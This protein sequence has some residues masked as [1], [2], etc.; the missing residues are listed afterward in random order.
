MRWAR[1]KTA[2]GRA[3]PLQPFSATCL[4]ALHALLR[5]PIVNRYFGRQWPL[6]VGRT[7]QERPWWDVRCRGDAPGAAPPSWA[8]PHTR[9]T[10]WHNRP[11]ASIGLYTMR[12]LP[13]RPRPNQ[14]DFT[15]SPISKVGPPGPN[16]PRK[17]PS[18]AGFG[19]SEFN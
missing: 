15:Y 17:H 12:A 2:G 3:A 4:P 6:G 10:P 18:L 8:P 7:G 9:R 19:H 14:A 11:G 1:E 13:P 16:S 5:I